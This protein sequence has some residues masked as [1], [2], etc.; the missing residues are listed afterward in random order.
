M[1]LWFCVSKFGNEKAKAGSVGGNELSEK[2]LQA[3][4]YELRALS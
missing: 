4:S 1:V 3:E 2:K